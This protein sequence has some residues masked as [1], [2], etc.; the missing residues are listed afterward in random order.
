MFMTL[1]SVMKAIIEHKGDNDFKIPYASKAKKRRQ[2]FFGEP[3]V[4]TISSVEEANEVLANMN[5]R[6]H[7]ESSIDEI[8]DLFND[9]GIP[10]EIEY[11][12]F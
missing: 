4:V 7:D 6:L 10:E 12:E 3:E 11:Y 9:V 2:G 8:C 1:R 5:E